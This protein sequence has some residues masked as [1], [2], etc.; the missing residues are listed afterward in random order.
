MDSTKASF[1]HI[2]TDAHEDE[3]AFV[4]HDG[5]MLHALPNNKKIVK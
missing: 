3:E 2:D 1:F 5:G 4:A